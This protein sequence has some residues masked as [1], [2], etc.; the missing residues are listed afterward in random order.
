M[1]VYLSSENIYNIAIP[2]IGFLDLSTCELD[3]KNLSKKDIQENLAYKRSVE[4]DTRIVQNFLIKSQIAKEIIREQYSI[5]GGAADP[6]RKI[7]LRE[8]NKSDTKRWGGKYSVLVLTLEKDDP[9]I[10]Y[11]DLM[12]EALHLTHPV[13]NDFRDVAPLDTL[14]KIYAHITYALK[15]AEKEKSIAVLKKFVDD[16]K[17]KHPNLEDIIFNKLLGIQKP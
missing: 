6:V 10:S 15:G 3:K 1:K 2:G 12:Q 17:N 11:E 4:I 5:I 14:I 13:R 8:E 7:I 9:F 16:H